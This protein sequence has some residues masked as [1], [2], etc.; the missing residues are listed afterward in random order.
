MPPQPQV[1]RNFLEFLKSFIGIVRLLQILLG[2]GLWVTIAA[3]KLNPTA[4]D[5][6]QFRYLPA[7]PN[8]CFC[9]VSQDLLLHRSHHKHLSS[10][11]HCILPH[12]PALQKHQ[13]LRDA[14]IQG[15]KVEGKEVA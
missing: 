11:Q 3:N 4:P 2:A 8:H 13:R 6:Q 9:R 15:K 1:K 14:A 7:G 12:L 5:I 10:A